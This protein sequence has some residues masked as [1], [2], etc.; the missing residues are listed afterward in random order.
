MWGRVWEITALDRSGAKP[1]KP[2]VDSIF[3]C[4]FFGPEDYPGTHV[5]LVLFVDSAEADFFDDEVLGTI[6]AA[7]R[8]FV[9]LLESLHKLRALRP[10]PTFY[11]GYKVWA[12][13][14]TREV[15]SELKSLGVRFVDAN[16]HGWKESLTFRS[17]NSLDLEL[18]RSMKPA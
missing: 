18:G 10:V 6:S 17:L 7:C 11:P 12:E 8:G 3:A 2:Y 1:I 4:P 13:S 15:V 9:Q 14:D 5:S 16:V